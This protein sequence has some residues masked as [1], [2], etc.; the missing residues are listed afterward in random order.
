[1]TLDADDKRILT[2]IARSSLAAAVAGKP[3][4]PPATGRPALLAKC[5]CFVT[6]KTGGRLRGC[7]GCFTSPAPLYQ[8]VAEY[9]RHSALDDPRFV[10]D[11]LG[12]ADLAKVAMDISVLSPL[13]TCR[14]PE[15]I[16]PGVH[17][18]F[19]SD[20]GR[21]GCFLPQVASE[22]HWTVEEFWGH[23]CRDK[24]GLAWDAWRNPGVR[25]STFT[26]EVFEC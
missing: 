8:T 26:A 22:M 6:L 14:E 16:V 1:M 10:G 15:K 9:T 13:E 24:A 18:I 19:V 17:G 11:R 20:G 3:Y 2:S 12:P 7:I 5:G 4:S 23:C 25:L 21:Q